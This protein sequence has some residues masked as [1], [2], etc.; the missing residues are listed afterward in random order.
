VR[1]GLKERTHAVENGTSEHGELGTAMIDD[2]RG[3]R[4]QHPIGDVGRTWN[5]QEM[6]TRTRHG[7]SGVGI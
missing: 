2:R 1:P 7:T 6:A 4:A 5:L 3:H